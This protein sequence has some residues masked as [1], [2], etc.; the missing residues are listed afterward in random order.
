MRCLEKDRGRRYDTA[1]GL[2]L[3]IERH[4]NNE[5][6]TARPPSTVYL[7][8]KL[9]RR[10]RF[11]FIASAAMTAMFATGFA[12]ST[13]LLLRV[14]EALERARVL[15]ARAQEEKGRAQKARGEAEANHLRAQVEAARRSQL[16]ALMIE[17][18]DRTVARKKENGDRPDVE[19]DM[20]ESLAGTY[21]TMGEYARAEELFGKAKQLRVRLNG[22][23]SP[24]AAQS[25]NYLGLVQSAQGRWSDAERSHAEALRIQQNH[26]RKH[27]EAAADVAHTHSTLGWALAQQAKLPEAEHH[28]TTAIAQQ[29]SLLGA[30]DPEV[31]VSLIRLGS[32]L[33]QSGRMPAAE[34]A[35]KQ[36]L[37]INT[38]VFGEQ[39]SEVVRTLHSLAVTVALDYSRL[40]EAI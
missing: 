8:Q 36:A 14:R 15:E 25:L 30:R 19:A 20:T 39:S 6:V 18:L 9:L 29:R 37:A 32:V 27:P 34:D 5:P 23:E 12:V 38:A 28:L 33:T 10:H 35:L 13:V 2:A 3:D 16:A 24:Q 22:E 17:Y 1:N 40:G 26:V 21:F 31:A 4:L 11:A 7:L